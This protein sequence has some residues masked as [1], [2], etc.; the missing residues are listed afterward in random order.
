MKS[1]EAGA[2]PTKEESITETLLE[3]EAITVADEVVMDA[4]MMMAIENHMVTIGNK[5]LIFLVFMF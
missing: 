2:C 1:V 5:M 3:I 4:I